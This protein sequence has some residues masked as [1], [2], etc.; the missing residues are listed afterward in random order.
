MFLTVLVQYLRVPQF[1][2][3]W[4]C[5]ESR[6]YSDG[7]ILREAW[8][9]A[10]PARPPK[11]AAIDRRISH[12]PQA[13]RRFSRNMYKLTAVLKLKHVFSTNLGLLLCKS[14]DLPPP[15]SSSATPKTAVADPPK[16]PRP[17]RF[18]RRSR[19]VFAFSSQP[20]PLPKATG[21]PADPRCRQRGR[22]ACCTSAS[23]SRRRRDG[24]N[25]RRSEPRDGGRVDGDERGRNNAWP[26]WPKK[27]GLAG[28]KALEREAKSGGGGRGVCCDVLF[29]L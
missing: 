16:N 12:K 2:H 29:H 4:R 11:P 6:G 20:T 27:E 9:G 18:H 28:R 14:K 17:F 3:L 7:H 26:E 13:T 15:R 10:I 1:S 23:S 5:S 22:S 21:V 25:P 24:A 8:L 19:R